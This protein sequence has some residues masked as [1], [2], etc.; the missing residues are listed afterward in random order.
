MALTKMTTSVTNI[1]NLSD[2]P[3]TTDGLTSSE[4]KIRFDKAGMD[5]KDYLNTT[6]T[7]ELDTKIRSIESQADNIASLVSFLQETMLGYLDIYPVGSIY[8]SVNNTNPGTMFGGTWERIQDRFLLASG[9]TYGAGTTG[10]EAT[11]TLTIN[12][13]PSHTHDIHATIG[14]G[15]RI[16]GG[17]N[18]PGG[19]S[20][21][22]IPF[23]ITNNSNY[24]VNRN[25]GGGQAHNNMPPYLAVYVWKRVS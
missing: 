11:H 2:L 23:T 19:S 15:G 22:N 14:G 17:Y 5:L 10:G 9:S 1:Q 24:I 7:E 25:T 13:M 18:A 16:N 21:Y 12:E 8:I 6:L 3:N 4:L 20:T